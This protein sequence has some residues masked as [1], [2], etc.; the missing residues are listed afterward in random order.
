MKFEFFS[1][2]EGRGLIFVTDIFKLGIVVNK[3]VRDKNII[4][5]FA[6]V[7]SCGM[8]LLGRG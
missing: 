4:A 2:G 8:E 3:Y 7:A 1:S 6:C 5:N